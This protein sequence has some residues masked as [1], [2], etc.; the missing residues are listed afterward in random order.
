L[1]LSRRTGQKA[2]TET[3]L[4]MIVRVSCDG[5]VELIFDHLSVLRGNGEHSVPF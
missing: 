2:G 3:P 5:F 1:L 4:C